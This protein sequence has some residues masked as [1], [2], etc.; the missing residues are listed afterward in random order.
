MRH[1]LSQFFPIHFDPASLEKDEPRFGGE[2]APPFPLGKDLPVERGLDLEIEHGSGAEHPRD[3][4]AYGH[5]HGRARPLL[6]PIG[7]AQEQ[8]GFFERRRVLEKAVGIG[9]LPGERVKD[10]ARVH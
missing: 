8:S 6:P 7:H 5:S 4:V 9:R 10:F 3:S 1:G 2:Q